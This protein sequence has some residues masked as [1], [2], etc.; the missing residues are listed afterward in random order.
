[1]KEHWNR[2]PSCGY[3]M[4]GYVY[5]WHF[6]KGG[7]IWLETINERTGKPPKNYSD[8]QW[9][10]DFSRIREMVQPSS[11]KKM[12]VI[13]E[14]HNFVGTY[15]GNT[16]YQ[17]YCDFINDILSNIRRGEVDYCFY[18]Y[19]ISELLKYEHDRLQAELLPNDGCFKLSLN[20]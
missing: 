14:P 12:N 3:F 16:Q 5:I 10:Q 11:L 17:Y 2:N 19:Q 4:S 9:Q 8:L 15:H 18:I 6:E 1:M 7:K 13:Q 20:K